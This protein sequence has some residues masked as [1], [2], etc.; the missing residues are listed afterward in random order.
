MDQPPYKM[1]KEVPKL[2]YF[3]PGLIIIDEK[4]QMMEGLWIVS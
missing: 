1:G 2:I 4:F 3:T